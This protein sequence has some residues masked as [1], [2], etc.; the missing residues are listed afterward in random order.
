MIGYGNGSR[1]SCFSSLG[2][3]LV[4]IVDQWKPKPDGFCRIAN[5]N[6]Y[7]DLPRVSIP[8]RLLYLVRQHIGTLHV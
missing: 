8:Y 7:L 1:K 2:L 5:I 6:R 4:L 3:C